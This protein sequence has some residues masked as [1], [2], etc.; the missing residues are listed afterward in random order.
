MNII[1]STSKG[2]HLS[3]R[4]SDTKSIVN[5]PE[6]DPSK[7]DFYHDVRDIN[8]YWQ[9]SKGEVSD[10]HGP[11]LLE[12]FADKPG[13]VHKNVRFTKTVPAAPKNKT[14]RIGLA[15]LNGFLGGG[16]GA[17]AGGAAGG[18]LSG[19]ALAFGAPQSI[20]VPVVATAAATGAIVIGTQAAKESYA[21]N[22]FQYRPTEVAGTLE[23]KE[24]GLYFQPD[25]GEK[26]IQ[27]MTDAQRNE[28]IELRRN[29]AYQV[30]PV[31]ESLS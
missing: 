2:R 6:N 12:S 30:W 18:F 21:S 4:F 24:Q 27:V 23:N 11:L 26:S 20:T 14:A 15:S 29:P 31:T 19:L 10:K 17:V 9:N 13:V 7:A 16:L 22:A 3:G 25:D 28:R 8:H 5:T 1:S